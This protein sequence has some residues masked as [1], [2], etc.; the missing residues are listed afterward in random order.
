MSSTLNYP[1]P[2]TGRN[3]IV[4]GASR[5]LGAQ[6]ALDLAKAGANVL[7]NYTSASSTS[8]AEVIVEQIRKI[9]PAAKVGTFQADV[10]SVDIGSTTL[11]RAADLF[12]GGDTSDLKIHII[13]H[14]A[15][16]VDDNILEEETAEN[17]NTIFNVNVRGPFL[18]T[19]ALRPYIPSHDNARIIAVS[20]I[21]AR[22]NTPG[23]SIYGAS[24][25]ALE[26]FVRTWSNEFGVTEGITVNAVNPGPMRTDMYDAVSDQLKKT[27]DEQGIPIANTNDVS[28]VVLF[29][30]SKESRWVT[31]SVV[32]ANGGVVNI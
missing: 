26:S 21:A 17:V 10:G 19:Q 6:I 30:A 14:N 15:A 8:K 3:A 9:N 27:L 22:I 13:V 32:S 11:K 12:A 24:K 25:A 18:I 29:L 20:S 7:I 16:L 28:D 23:T 5:G 4:T 2:L 31:G 1:L